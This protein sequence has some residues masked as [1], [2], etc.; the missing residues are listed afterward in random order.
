MMKRLLACFLAAVLFLCCVP[1]ALAVDNSRDFFFELSVDGSSQKEVQPGDIIQVDFTLKRTDDA[2]DYTMYGMQNEIRYDSN[3][4]ELVDGSALLSSGISTTDIGLRDSYREFYMNF[5]SLS[6]GEEWNAQRLVGSFKLKVIAAS[7][8]TKITNQDY[9]VSTQ[10]GTDQYQA[11]CQDVTII[12]STACTVKFEPN[13]G[14]EVPSQTVQYG[15]TVERPEDPTR[16]GYH[17]EGW[18]SDIDLQSPWDFEKDTV[19]GNM[20]LYAKWE[21]GDAPTD[22]TGSGLWWLLGLGLLGLLLLLLLLLLLGRKTVRFE[23]GCD[24]KI[25][26]QKVKKGDL[27]KCPEQPVRPGRAFAGWYSDEACTKRWDFENDKV[28]DSMTL[29]AKWL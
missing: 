25:K 24:A 9:L 20:T 23:T 21:K 26:D 5:V 14:T 1:T 7:G 22:G 10:D 17:L 28:E 8:V 27:V 11:S 13:G 15:E 19:E 29:Y 16:E 6:G 18:Y 12:V 4:F 3:F 2:S